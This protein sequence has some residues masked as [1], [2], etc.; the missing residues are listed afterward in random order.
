MQFIF[1]NNLQSLVESTANILS[2][3]SSD[4]PLAE[5]W[6]VVPN[7][8]TG[9]WMQIQLSERLGG[10]ANTR[11][12]L[13]SRFLESLVSINEDPK[14]ETALFWAINT[15]W[16][17]AHRDLQDA[18]HDQQV[19]VLFK[20]FKQ[21]IKERPDWLMAWEKHE[22]IGP[23]NSDWQADLW[24][25][26]Q[27]ALP[28]KPHE[29]IMHMMQALDV[30]KLHSVSRLIIF[31]PDRLSPMQMVMVQHWSKKRICFLCIQSPSPDHWFTEGALEIAETHP[32]LP[33]L[34]REKAKMI[35]QLGDHHW[36]EGF[37]RPSEVSALGQLKGAIYDN[38]IKPI[39]IDDSIQLV[40]ATSPTQ[41]VQELKEWVIEWL[42]QDSNRTVQ[43]IQIV[44]PNPGLYGPII[45]RAFYSQNTR[46]RIPTAL[47]PL[48]IQPIEVTSIV[49]L[50]ES[51]RYGFNAS[52]TF[53]FFTEYST[54]EALKISDRQVREIEKWLILSGARRGVSGHRHSLEE[55][56]KRLLKG[57]LADPDTQLETDSVST[58]PL[59]Q[60]HTLDRLLA[61]LQAIEKVLDLPK[62]MYLK[63]AIEAIETSLAQLTL[64]KIQSLSL[65]DLTEPFSDKNVNLASVFNWLTMRQKTALYRPLALNDQISVTAPQTI[66]SIQSSLVAILGANHDTVPGTSNAHSW[67]LI[68]KAPRPS[69]LIP[70]Q[71]EKQV[72]FDVISNT[73]DQIWISWIGKH[74][75]RLTKEQP[76]PALRLLIQQL[77]PTEYKSVIQELP[78]GLARTQTYLAQSVGQRTDE[79]TKFDWALDEFLSA[80]SE[81]G[82]SFLS[83][84]GGYLTTP[85]PNVLGGEP[86]EINSLHRFKLQ[87]AFESEGLSNK[88]MALLLS[89]HPEFPEEIDLTKL[90]DQCAPSLVSQAAREP[91]EL[92]DAQTLSLG[93][94]NLSI[95]YLKKPKVSRI[96]ISKEVDG[97]RGLRALLECLV[98]YA[99]EPCDQEIRL[100]TFNNKVTPVG[101]ISQVEAANLLRQWLKL[102]SC[103]SSPCPLIGPIALKTAKAIE[104]G[105]E[106]SD[107][108]DW[109]EDKLKFKPEYRRLFQHDPDISDKHYQLTYE[110]VVPLRKWMGKPRANF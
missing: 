68:A 76:A 34:C 80:A 33:A 36:I 32:L 48:I 71:Q 13:L 8:D 95:D 9:R 23:E 45:Q 96:L 54:R 103:I 18:D 101:P 5:D 25:S 21:Y 39:S 43:Q 20:V 98:A 78:T 2:A 53:E 27:S 22:L 100:V 62:V 29:E 92:F 87:Q 11:V 75:I 28:S 72:L 79:T 1:S 77:I 89:N 74:P 55:A 106:S 3:D 93:P 57:L 59:E 81:P 49:L 107:R 66:R 109:A 40:A 31:N 4:S 44:S 16:H 91:E 67:D 10:L 104:S 97:N 102:I 37:E 17:Q 88:Q 90:L 108:I 15:A 46:H 41:E 24:R 58:E 60:S 70:S 35:S 105:L 26:V 94:F 52:R 7:Q 30:D 6:L 14:F 69:D 73:T 47:D 56:K 12:V 64:G 99:I 65:S 110:L 63:E 19:N 86:L 50:A 42:N 51:L 82:K 84:Q 38:Q 85:N 61:S 83:M